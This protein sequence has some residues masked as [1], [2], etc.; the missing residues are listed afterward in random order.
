MLY[1]F[2]PATMER[3]ANALG[4]KIE[5]FDKACF[6]CWEKYQVREAP[7]LFPKLK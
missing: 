1:P 7:I 5:N 2:M 3:L 6:G 4:F